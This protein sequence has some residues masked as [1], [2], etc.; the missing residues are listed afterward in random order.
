MN[1]QNITGLVKTIQT[2]VVKHSPEILTGI[3]IAGMVTTTIFAVKVTPKA[4]D[5]I[6]KA[7]DENATYGDGE[8]LTK[9]EIVRVA[10]KPYIPAALTCIA[11]IACL[12]GASSVNFRRNAALATAYKLSEAA[13]TEYKDAVID[14]IGEKK[15]QAVKEKISKN[16]VEQNPVSNNTIYITGDGDT[17]F[18]EPISKRYFY[19]DIEQVRS[20]INTLNETLYNDPFGHI[21]L[22]DLYDAVGLAQ[23]DIS[24]DIGWNINGGSIKVDFHPAMS[25][26]GKPCLALYY[27]T[28]P[29]WDYDK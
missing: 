24:N 16:R 2:S 6:A 12:I 3:G 25:D 27:E 4:L 11:S 28:A 13:L 26:K 7:E 8:P 9:I 14:T 29:S 17:L 10:W 1:K 5:L 22:S 15:E 20:I 19:S 18:L 21:P 23:T